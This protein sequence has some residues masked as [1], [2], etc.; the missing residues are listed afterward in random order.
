MSLLISDLFQSYAEY[1]TRQSDNWIKLEEVMH[2]THGGLVT[3]PNAFYFEMIEKTVDSIIDTG[4]LSYL[5]EKDIGKKLKF[6]QAKSE[7]KV[8]NMNDL[9]FGFN[10]WLG[11]CFL[12][13]ISFVIELIGW[14]IKKCRLRNKVEFLT[15]PS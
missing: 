12:S 8:L 10:I 9:S 2:V 15:S 3:Q 11:C 13:A 14:P 7:P 6:D 1:K 5:I 4:I